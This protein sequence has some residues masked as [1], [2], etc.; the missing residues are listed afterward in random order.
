MLRLYHHLKILFKTNF[1]LGIYF[2]IKKLFY[3]NSLYTF[4]SYHKLVDLFDIEKHLKL[5]AKYIDQ[6]GTKNQLLKIADDFIYGNINIYDKNVNINDYT[7]DQ[8]NLNRSKNQIY[9]KD[10]RF[11]WEVYRSNFLYNVSLAYLITKN[12]DYAN[13]ISDYIANWRS[14]SPITTKT[15]R[16]N[17]MESSIKLINLSFV[18]FF[19]KTHKKYEENIKPNLTESIISHANY[20][21]INYDITIYGLESNHALSCGIGLLYASYLVPNYSNARKWRKLGL[22][23]IKRALRNQFSSDGV[24]FESSTNYHRFI[25]EMLLFILAILY[26]HGE[27]TDF[28]IENRIIQISNCLN[29][30]THLNGMISRFGDSDGGKF[31]PDLGLPNGFCNLDYINWF[32]SYNTKVFYETILFEGI[33]QLKNIIQNYYSSGSAGR[34]FILKDSNISLIFNANNIGTY[35]KGNH[36]HN[37][38]LSFE[39][40]GERPFIVDPW[41][42][43]YTGSVSLRNRDRVTNSH[44][45]IKVDNREIVPFNDVHLFEMTG[46]VNV[47]IISYS[48]NDKHW[49]TEA[50]HD[51]Y[52]NLRNGSQYHNRKIKYCKTKKEIEIIDILSGKGTHDARINFHIPKKDWKLSTENQ[53]LVFANEDEM[54]TI[55]NNLGKFNINQGFVSSGFLKREPSYQL[56]IDKE[57]ENTLKFIT[58][59]KYLRAS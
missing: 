38:F 59:I 46:R 8:F 7:L 10:I 42:Y 23:S 40:Y 51:G 58:I 17:G 28:K 20:T 9:N 14:Y 33:P 13:A 5:I 19:L 1:V 56:F 48:G 57:Y 4:D 45:T 31:L 3:K 34:Y 12:E 6:S 49:I 27:K 24:N 18:H 15:V 44:N 16:Y 25:T 41:S 11:Q 39:L 22:R 30:L 37:D 26:K 54:F 43:C 36:Q 53:T 50:C 47:K 52:S 32:N 29:R 55:S 21:L 35:G 2:K